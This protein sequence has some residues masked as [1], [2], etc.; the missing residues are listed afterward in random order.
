LVSLWEGSY[1]CCHLAP[2][3]LF[4]FLW[5]DHTFLFLYMPH[6]FCWELE[7]LNIIMW[8][9][10]KSDFP[11]LLPKVYAASLGF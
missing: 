9:L 8:L 4:H 3:H 6:K 5:V 7:N 11:Q 1:S 2:P 10:W